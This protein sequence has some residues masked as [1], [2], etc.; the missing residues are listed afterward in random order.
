[1]LVLMIVFLHQTSILQYPVLSP[2]LKPPFQEE[3]PGVPEGNPLR[4][5]ERFIPLIPWLTW[6]HIFN[7]HATI[8][9]I[10]NIFIIITSDTINL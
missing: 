8:V 6:A 9:Q 5:M 2:L 7:A 10:N 3:V 4:G 1:M